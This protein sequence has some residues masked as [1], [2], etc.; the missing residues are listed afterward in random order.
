MVWRRKTKSVC[1]RSIVDMVND[2]YDSDTPPPLQ[3]EDDD[4]ENEDCTCT[5]EGAPSRGAWES[6]INVRIVLH[7]E[8]INVRTSDELK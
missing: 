3:D 2:D 6:S 5:L 1:F 7:V 4:D 8:M